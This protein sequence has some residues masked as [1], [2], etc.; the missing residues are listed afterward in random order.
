MD[1][2]NTDQLLDSV[3]DLKNFANTIISKASDPDILAKM[4]AKDRDFIKSAK[5]AV[6]AKGLDPK[7]MQDK[8]NEV[9]S[10]HGK[11]I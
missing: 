11:N 5:N 10:K 2:F 7:E 8:L 1:N 6:N 9:M 3:K 4:D